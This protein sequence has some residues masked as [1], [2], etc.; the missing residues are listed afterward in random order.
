MGPLGQALL[1]QAVENSVCMP[2]P[3]RCL[4]TLTGS[5]SPAGCVPR[6]LLVNPPPLA[7][8]LPPPLVVRSL[9]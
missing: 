1:Q 8:S 2:P 6:L 3:S 9:G 4:V 7:A 5:W